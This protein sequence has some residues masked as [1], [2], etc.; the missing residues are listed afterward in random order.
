MANGTGNGTGN[1]VGVGLEGL[2]DWQKERAQAQ[3]AAMR[4][5]V[6]AIASVETLTEQL[7]GAERDREAALV[8]LAELG[9]G[10]ELLGEWT[11]LEVNPAPRKGRRREA[12]AG[13]VAAG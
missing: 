13:V 1:S 7:A 9:V 2:R 3:Q 8:E 4:K 6:Q 5:W 11:G 12:P 10:P